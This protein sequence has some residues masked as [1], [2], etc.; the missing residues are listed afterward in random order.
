VEEG[1]D[2]SDFFCCS[3]YEVFRVTHS[4]IFSGMVFQTD[5]VNM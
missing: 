3:F 2:M 1:R 5:F 4:E